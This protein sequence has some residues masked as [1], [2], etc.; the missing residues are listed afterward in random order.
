MNLK[1]SIISIISAGLLA[2]PVFAETEVTTKGGIEVESGDFSFELGGRIQLDYAW[3]DEDN[4]PMAEGFEFRRARLFAAGTLYNEWDYKAQ[5]DFAGNDLTAK[6]LYIKY[7]GW[8]AGKITIG[9]FKQPFSLDELT[10]S[11]YI[12]FMERALPNA[13]ATGRRIGVGYDMASDNMSFAASVY[14]QDVDTAEAVAGDDADPGMGLGARYTFAPI[15][16]DRNVL[17]FGL[18]V[19]QEEPASSID[20]SVSFRQRPEVHLAERLVDTGDIAAVD[21]ILK[22]GVEAAWVSG[23]FSAQAEYIMTDVS[24]KS[25]QPDVGFDGYYAF[26][27][28]F[29]DG[30]TSRPYSKGVFKR[31]KARG[32]WELALRYSSLDLNDIDNGIAGGELNDITLAANYYVNPNL[33]F[34]IN[35]VMA[36]GDYGVLGTEEP[37]ALQVR[38]SFDF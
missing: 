18:S 8:D 10:S 12:T 21:S 32:V 6:D 16:G 9:Q 37:N 24:R 19:A 13:F 20:E 28:Y 23:P 4:I 15:S 36:E 22:G 3:I 34:M 5:Y 27:S 2:G 35:Y 14:G 30:E 26:A 7:T 1:A 38:A 17:H 25:G 11:K 31:V 29:L 33:R